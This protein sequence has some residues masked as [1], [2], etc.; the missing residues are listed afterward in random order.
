MPTPPWYPFKSEEKK[1]RYLA[2]YE[3]GAARWPVPSQTR[4]VDTDW[5]RTFV[6]LSGPAAAP[7]LV[8]LPGLGAPG[9]SLFATARSLSSRYR[10]IAVDNIW[11][12]GR[13][14]A[15]RQVRN[16]DDFSAWLDGLLTALGLGAG[17]NLLG[18][19]YGGWIMTQYALR[20]PD[21]VRGLVMLA[22]AG[23]V[24]PIPWAFIWRATLCLLPGKHW[25]RSFMAYAS[26]ELEASP[27]NRALMDEL[28]EDATV[29]LRCFARRPMVAP[30]PLSDDDWKR[31]TVPALF[32][33]GD[34]EVFFPPR[35]SVAMLKEKARAVRPVLIPGA[36]HDLFVARADEVSRLVLEFLDAPHGSRA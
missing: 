28:T 18:L 11:D 22:P 5:G 27:A 6:R 3:V 31:L 35:E 1:A 7:P 21:R 33:C 4:E 24:A 14:V 30:M 20:H 12:S 17:I 23:T 8:M 15:A 10:T 2:R 25:M 26:P 16:A 13:S 34:R 32:I 36:G 19:S 9:Q 29:A